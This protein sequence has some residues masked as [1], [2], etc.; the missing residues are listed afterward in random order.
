MLA[1][2]EPVDPQIVDQIRDVVESDQPPHVVVEQAKQLIEKEGETD[3][4]DGAPR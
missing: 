2:T 4:A 1:M 3:G